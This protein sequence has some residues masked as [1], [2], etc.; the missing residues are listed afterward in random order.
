MRLSCR[1]EKRFETVTK[2][3]SL[4]QGLMSRRQNL[5]PQTTDGQFVPL[6]QWRALDALSADERPPFAQQIHDPNARLRA[7]DA[8]MNSRDAVV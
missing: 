6:L 8:A 1:N 4:D 2:V 3:T 7:D 5:H